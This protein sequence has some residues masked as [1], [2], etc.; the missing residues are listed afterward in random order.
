MRGAD[1]S[2]EEVVGEESK[3]EKGRS[4]EEEEVAGS[5]WPSDGMGGLM[6]EEGMAK[7]VSAWR[8]RRAR[9]VEYSEVTSSRSGPNDERKTDL[10]EVVRK[11]EGGRGGAGGVMI[12]T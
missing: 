11:E 8:W 3:E 12:L 4:R 10:A 9:T 2:E 7:G 1:E 6:K 5:D